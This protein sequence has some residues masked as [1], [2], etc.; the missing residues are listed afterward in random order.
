MARKKRAEEHENHERWLV[1]YAD[2]I[3]LLFAF[4]VS[5]YAISSV[6]E[7]KFRIM[8]EALAIAFNPSLYTSTR[9]QEGPRFVREQKSHMAHEFKDMNTN[10]FQKLQTALKKLEA[11]K[12]LTLLM[13]DQKITIR[14]SESTLFGPG[15]DDLVPEAIPVLNE[16]ANVLKD[17]PNNIRIEGHTDNIPINTEKFPSNWDLSSLRSIRILKFLVND[18]KYDP[19]K[20]SALGYGEY[21][22]IDTNDTPDGRNKNRRV[23]IMVVNG[24]AVDLAP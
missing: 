19:R 6:N 14:I 15:S 4:F 20:M 9:M 7:G 8:S 3:T 21:R 13:D 1:S 10:N 22:P 18:H 17:I 2:F 23:D 11:E 16:V 24:D 12:K 5:M